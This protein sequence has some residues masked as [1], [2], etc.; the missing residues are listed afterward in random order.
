MN[1]RAAAVYSE[2]E[3]LRNKIENMNYNLWFCVGNSIGSQAEMFFPPSPRVQQD[4]D[5]VVPVQE[6]ERLLPG[7][8]GKIRLLL[9]L[10][11]Q[12]FFFVS[13]NKFVV[14]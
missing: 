13:N 7:R 10:I 11:K 14:T 4:R 5:V 6:D 12:H 1:H 8:M 3:Y 2:K 9:T